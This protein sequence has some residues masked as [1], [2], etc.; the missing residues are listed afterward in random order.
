[1]QALE[2]SGVTHPGCVVTPAVS[3]VT[4]NLVAG[5]LAWLLKKSSTLIT[6]KP[7]PSMKLNELVVKGIDYVRVT[8]SLHGISIVPGTF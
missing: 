1:M 5:Q 8:L 4:L 6:C 2:L 3:D 7:S